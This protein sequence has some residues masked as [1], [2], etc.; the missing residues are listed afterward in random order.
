[1]WGIYYGNYSL[2]YCIKY[3]KVVESRFKYPLF[4]VVL[5]A[6]SWS[7]LPFPSP[8]ESSGPKD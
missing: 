5:V 3:L 8:R 4:V 2:Q 1:M 6:K 7:G